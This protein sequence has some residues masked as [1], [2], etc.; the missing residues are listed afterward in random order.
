MRIATHR[1]IIRLMLALA[2]VWGS[3]GVVKGQTTLYNWN[4]EDQN[5]IVDGGILASGQIIT[6]NSTGS[7]AYSTG[8]GGAGSFAISNNGWDNGANTKYWHI[9]VNIQGYTNITLSSKQTSSNTGPKNFKA[10]YCVDGGTNWIDVPSATITIT[11]ANAFNGVLTDFPLPATCSNQVDLQLRWIMTS[12]TAT[13]GTTVASTGTSRIDDI[14]VKGALCNVVV[15]SFVPSTGPIGTKVTITGTNFT[16]ATNVLFSGVSAA[17]TVIDNNTITALVPAVTASGPITVIG[18]SCTSASTSQ[19]QINSICAGNGSNLIISELCDPLY[20]YQTSRYIEFYNPTSNPILLTAWKM[21]AIGN[22]SECFTWNL[23]G[24][25]QPGQAMTCGNNYPA[26]GGPH[27]FGDAAWVTGTSGCCFNWNG[28]NDGAALYNGTTL[29]DL[30]YNSSDWFGNSSLIRNANICNPST[31]ANLSEWTVSAVA[32]AGTSPSTPRS[33]IS[34][35]TGTPPNITLQPI[36]LPTCASSTLTYIIAANGG[37]APYTYQWKYHNGSDPWQNITNGSNY[38]GATTASLTITTAMSMNGYQ[39]YCEVSNAGGTCYTSSNAVQLTV[40]ALPIATS[41]NNGPVC[42]DSGTLDLTGG[43]NG[44]TTYS[45]AGPNGFTASTQNASIVSPTYAANGIYTLTVTAANSC[46]ATT[47]TT[48]VINTLPPIPT[49]LPTYA[50]AGTKPL[51]TAGNGSIFEFFLNGASQG[52]SST[53]NTYTPNANL[54]PSDQVCVRSYSPFFDG[55]LTETTWGT[56]LATSAGGP[57]PSGFGAGNNIDA[58]YMQSTS[59]YLYGG[60]AGNL[61]NG[62]GNRVLLFIDCQAGGYNVIGN[63]TNRTNAP[64]NSM[65]N[66]NNGITFATGFEPDYILGINQASNNVYFDLYNMTSNSLNYLGDANTSVLLGFVANSG[67]GDYLHG[68]EF[69]IPRS[70]LGNPSGSIKVFA[71]ITNNPADADATFLSN[72][73]LTRANSGEGNYGAG[74]I[75]FQNNADPKPI[76]YT[77]SSSNCNSEACVTVQA[78]P[79]ITAGGPTTFCQGGSVLLTS[80]VG[81]S[82]LWSTGATT[83]SIT[84]STSGSYTVTVTDGHGCSAVSAATVVTVNALPTITLGSNPAVC[85]GTTAAN[86]PYS[87]ATGSPN[88]YSIVW[89]PEAHNAGFIDVPDGTTLPSTPIVLAVPADAAAAPYNGTLTVKNSTTGCSS[90]GYSISVTINPKPTTSA[91]YH[92]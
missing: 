48:A 18:A 1:L 55:N 17:F 72:Q 16:G 35:C 52:A 91:I 8:T 15:S 14:L 21:K 49:L 42:A 22:N 58:I 65:E 29:V 69:A 75:I 4:F 40:K 38:A 20:G 60:I 78:T 23:S 37:T 51:F 13:N 79:T 77:F 92:Q 81:S 39:Y 46:T 24:T 19:F 25:I 89:I 2:G 11:A 31:I 86:L 32:N 12:N 66:L 36:S 34:N 45:W 50:C 9:G 68:F 44:M 90:T 27:N 67:F 5:T 82:Y 64:C 87:A 33:H 28:N 56:P 30:I 84:V 10:Q 57:N 70:S 26:D 74:A 80:S 85:A 61:V 59:G 63:W 6:T 83:Q 7:V 47:T 73:F 3:V 43:A 41:S 88:Q 71:M 54:A 76:D 62:S 53:L